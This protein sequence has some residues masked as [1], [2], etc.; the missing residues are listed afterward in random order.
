MRKASTPQGRLETEVGV[1]ATMQNFFSGK[2]VFVLKAFN[3]LD[4]VHPSLGG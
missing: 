3:Q 1:D 4:E 2:A